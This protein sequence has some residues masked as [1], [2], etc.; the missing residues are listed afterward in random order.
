MADYILEMLYLVDRKSIFFFPIKILMICRSNIPGM[1][2]LMLELRLLLRQDQ[3]CESLTQKC[4]KISP[5]LGSMWPSAC[6]SMSRRHSSPL[7]MN[8]RSWSPRKAL[9]LWWASSRITTTHSL[10][11]WLTSLELTFQPDQTDLRWST[12]SSPSASIHAFASRPT[13]TSSPPSSRSTTY[14]RCSLAHSL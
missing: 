7:E 2:E 5:S 9:C 1:R 14:L 8:W 12:T 10:A 4:A 11:P 6:P 3:L 13:L